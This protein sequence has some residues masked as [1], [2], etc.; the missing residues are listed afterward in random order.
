LLLCEDPDDCDAQ[1]RVHTCGGLL[2]TRGSGYAEIHL[3]V[4]RGENTK[5]ALYEREEEHDRR[6]AD[7]LALTPDARE[8]APAFTFV[9]LAGPTEDALRAEAASAAATSRAFTVEFE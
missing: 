3:V 7:F 6:D 8:A 1:A 4:C 2:G 5:Y 9:R